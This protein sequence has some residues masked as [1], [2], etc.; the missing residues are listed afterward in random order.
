M[1]SKYDSLVKA[2]EWT[3]T[4]TVNEEEGSHDIESVIVTLVANIVED[5]EHD[6]AQAH[7]RRSEHRQG[8]STPEPINK[9]D[10]E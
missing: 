7:A 2:G 3:L 6:H 8:S 5:R 1:I 9:E 10:G 4:C